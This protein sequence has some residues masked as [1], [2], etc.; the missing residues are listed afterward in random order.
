[1]FIEITIQGVTPLICN[2]FFDESAEKATAGV[3]QASVAGSKGTPLEQARKKLY[4]NAEDSPVIPQPNLVRCIA[5]GGKFFKNGKKQI[6]TKSESL[7]Y[8]CFDI[9]GAEIPISHQEPWRVDTRA[10]R[11]PATGG[12][13]LTHRP[14]FDD[15]ALS[16]TAELD[17]EMLAPTLL[18][19]IIDAAGK[20]IGLGDFRVATKGPYGKF[21]VTQWAID[22]T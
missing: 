13:I 22:A 8:S 16:F 21:V 2:R 12:R 5:D 7:L 14:L 6:T 15:W 11:I 18:R 17:A 4:L 10:V 1:M 9:Q 3:R 19:D 20:R